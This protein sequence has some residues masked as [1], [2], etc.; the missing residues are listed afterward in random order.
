MGWGG[1]EGVIATGNEHVGTDHCS[2]SSR[3][4][5]W[6][7]TRLRQPAHTR[8]PDGLRLQP[9]PRPATATGSLP[10]S[11]RA[12]KW[13]RSV[14]RLLSSLFLFLFA[15][16][17]RPISSHRPPTRNGAFS[18]AYSLP[19]AYTSCFHSN[20]ILGFPQEPRKHYVERNPHAQGTTMFF[21]FSFLS[22]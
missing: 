17:H 6:R 12:T 8:L 21:F 9:R 19:G 2:G 4:L 11:S 3:K 10:P 20:A 18:H 1:G 5:G 16:D 15:C 22:V 13:A 14:P 7:C